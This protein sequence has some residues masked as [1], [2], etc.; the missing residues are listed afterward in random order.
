VDGNGVSDVM[1]LWTGYNYAEGYWMNGTSEWRSTM[2]IHPAEW[3]TLGCY[4]MTGDGKADSVLVGNVEIGGNK[5]AYIGYYADAND[6]D[7]NW[8]NIDYLNNNAG[9]NWI[10][11]IG[12]LTGGAANSIVWYAPDLYTL[13]AWTDGTANWVTIT[14]T[15]GGDWTLVGCG[16]FDGDGKDSILMTAGGAMYYAADLD[17]TV[18]SM[19]D[20]NWSGWEV[21]AIGDFKGDGKEDLVLFHKELGSMVMCADGNLDDFTSIGQLDAIDWFVVGAGDYNGDQQ[22]DLLV[23]QYSTGMLGYYSGGDVANGWVELGR[24]VDMNWTVI[25]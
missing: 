5:G 21:R 20:A 12:N 8:V 16:D 3:E 13:G 7:D 1:F 15:F 24:G 10:N 18:K 25:A 11:K 6:T 4:D 19:G 14:G 9:V 2:A 23:R 22:D 17:G